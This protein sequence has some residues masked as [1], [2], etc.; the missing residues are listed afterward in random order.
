ML[1]AGSI[2]LSTINNSNKHISEE[3]EQKEFT[4]IVNNLSTLPEEQKIS[5]KIHNI[6]TVQ[7][8]IGAEIIKEENFIKT[9]NKLDTR[10]WRQGHQFSGG[11]STII[12]PNT[13]MVSYDENK[14]QFTFYDNRKSLL[15]SFDLMQLL[16]YL[17]NGW[18]NNF[19]KVDMGSAADIISKVVGTI[20]IDKN[21]NKIDI[22]LKPFSEKS[23]MG[24]IELLIKLNNDLYQYDKNTLDNDLL[25]IQDLKIRKKVKLT[26]RQFNYLLLT[27]MLRLIKD[28]SE[29]IKNDN[30]GDRIKLKASLLKYSVFITY[31]LGS[32]IRD[33]LNV[34]MS[35]IENV[36]SNIEK[37]VKIKELIADKITRVANEVEKQNDKIDK[38]INIDKS[39]MEI[40]TKDDDLADILKPYTSASVEIS[41]DKTP[42]PHI[43]PFSNTIDEHLNMISR[44]NGRNNIDELFDTDSENGF[45]SGGEEIDSLVN[46]K[47]ESQMSAIL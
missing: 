8:N 15:G 36:N 1:S 7:S 9:N 18:D 19:I 21:N 35:Y 27:H 5:E 22:K 4:E 24:N 39:S 29:E 26:I 28:I 33:Q 32:F 30:T 12:D 41:L 16:K 31:R 17:T 20:E 34:Q 46:T 38:I 14:K 11:D 6:K 25:K 45:E 13:L 23:L 42:K 2:T 10:V 43:K 37:L 3:S 44:K 40:R 47:T